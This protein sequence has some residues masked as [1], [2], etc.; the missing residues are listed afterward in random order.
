M[1]F[2]NECNAEYSEGMKFCPQCG[3]SIE[4]NPENRFRPFCSERCKLIDLGANAPQEL[5]GVVENV[6]FSLPKELRI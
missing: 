3:A 2:C 4:W 1:G 5:D 6:R